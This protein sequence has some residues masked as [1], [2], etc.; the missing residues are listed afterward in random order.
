MKIQR[1]YPYPYDCN[2]YIKNFK[3]EKDVFYLHL[4]IISMYK[5]VSWQR[6]ATHAIQSNPMLSFYTHH[7][8]CIF[9]SPL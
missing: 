7:P 9:C 6:N 8:K 5:C 3:R 1:F 4:G 2:L